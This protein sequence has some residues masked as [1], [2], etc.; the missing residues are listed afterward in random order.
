[1]GQERES[2]APDDVLPPITSPDEV[3]LNLYL[4]FGFEDVYPF[5]YI[6]SRIANYRPYFDSWKMAILEKDSNASE[7]DIDYT[8]ALKCCLMLS[9]IFKV[10]VMRCPDYER[11]KNELWVISDPKDTLGLGQF[12]LLTFKFWGQLGIVHL[13]QDNRN[14]LDDE[15][16]IV[17]DRDSLN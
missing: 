15:V 5:S 12:H 1:M 2:S 4:Y 14:D 9:D 6:K 10:E 16:I 3:I 13:M 8:I 17:L 7:I 11:T